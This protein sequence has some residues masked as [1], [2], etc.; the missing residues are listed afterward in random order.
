M[1]Y[2]MIVWESSVNALGDEFVKELLKECIKTHPASA[3]G[4]EG[5]GEDFEV[6]DTKVSNLVFLE[7]YRDELT[8]NAI[9]HWINHKG[10]T[11]IFR[12]RGEFYVKQVS[13]PYPLVK[14]P[15]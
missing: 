1:K 9:A 14:L 2:F 12:H 3:E 6:I 11:Q 15:E 7:T 4:I 13:D 8:E 5:I 10:G